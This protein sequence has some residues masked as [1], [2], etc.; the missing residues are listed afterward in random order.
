MGQALETRHGH[1]GQEDMLHDAGLLKGLPDITAGDLNMTP[2]LAGIIQ[3]NPITD[4]MR[5]ALGEIAP[6]TEADQRPT[7]TDARRHKKGKHDTDKESD[8]SLD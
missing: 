2:S 8:E 3:Q 4:N 6:V 7:V 1:E 5:F